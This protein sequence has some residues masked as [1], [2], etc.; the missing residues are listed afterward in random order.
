MEYYSKILYG[1]F[2]LLF[3]KLQS[4]VSFYL[5][6]EAHRADKLQRPQL[7]LQHQVLQLNELPPPKLG[8]PENCTVSSYRKINFTAIK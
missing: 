5:R 8:I 2:Q 3:Q 7:Q 6:R 4:E 1:L